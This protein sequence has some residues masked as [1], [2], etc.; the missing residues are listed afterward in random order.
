M[1]APPIFVSWSTIFSPTETITG[2]V[3]SPCAN[4][5]NGVIANILH[6]SI[7]AN[8]IE[9]KKF[10][11]F[12]F[13][14]FSPFSFFNVPLAL[15]GKGIPFNYY[16]FF[17]KVASNSAIVF[18]LTNI[19]IIKNIPTPIAI[20]PTVEPTTIPA[21]APADNPCSSSI[22]CPLLVSPP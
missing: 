17:F 5:V 18:F 3:S 13:I 2:V 15:V 9:I 1:G 20:A 22:T 19:H 6:I 11:D 7:N 21:I 16:Y 8:K 14:V 10:L 4:A 12:V